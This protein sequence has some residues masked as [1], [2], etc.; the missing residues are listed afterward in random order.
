MYQCGGRTQVPTPE[1]TL[2]P[3]APR[4]RIHLELRRRKHPRGV[5]GEGTPI[6]RQVAGGDAEERGHALALLVIVFALYRG[7]R[8][9]SQI[10]GEQGTFDQRGIDPAEG[11]NLVG[12][13]MATVR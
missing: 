8:G 10:V 9:Q 2:F 6:L 3:S 12:L 11:G 5:G 1:S 7:E 13:I 4:V